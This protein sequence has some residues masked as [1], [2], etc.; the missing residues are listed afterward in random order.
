MDTSP[1]INRPSRVLGAFAYWP[2]N[3][4]WSFQF[5]RMVEQAWSG[6][7][8]FAECHAVAK[9]LPVGDGEAWYAGFRHLAARTE[10]AA[11][12]AAIGGHE[13]SAREFW[14]RAS[15]YHRA[16]GFF[17]S[18]GDPRHG[19]GVLARRR[20]FLAAAERSPAAIEPVE[21]PYEDTTLPGYRF[22]PA[23]GS[24]SSGPA[25]IIYGGA[26]A[27]AEEMYFF[28][29]RALSDR[30][31]TVLSMDGPG[32]GE[33]LRRGIVARPDWEVAVTAAFDLL[34]GRD[35]VDAERIVMV[36]QSLGG[37]Y[38]TRA[39]AFEPRLRACGVWGALYSLH[40]ALSAHINGG[41]P[42]T[43]DHYIEQFKIVLG[44]ADASEVLAR[45]AEFTVAGAP[46]QISTPTL[47]VHGEDDMLCPV[48]GARR[49][50]AE[51]PGDGKEL[52]VYPS[53]QPGCTHCQV[54]ALPL[55]Q[56]D[57]STWLER[58]VRS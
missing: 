57:I 53:G 39:A 56:H 40:D 25:A 33:A 21:I 10:D 35:D 45:A 8:D 13:V 47:I 9:D 28:L 6:G 23:A 32:Q 37:L 49:L 38:A 3:P 15:N 42:R 18:P 20:C 48:G 2:D 27:V 36:G 54:D 31:F 26:D 12:N 4:F 55:V 16:A 44:G 58:R 30:G 52:I 50:F 19:D 24:P 46:D 41:D 17:L 29:G 22:G 43:A 1:T 5:L 11:E 14:M 34:A 51:I 7:A